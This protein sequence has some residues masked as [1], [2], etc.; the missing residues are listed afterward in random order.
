MKGREFRPTCEGLCAFS[1]TFPSRKVFS[2]YLGPLRKTFVLLG[3]RDG[4]LLTYARAAVDKRCPKAD[5]PKPYV[6]LEFMHKILE[7]MGDTPMTRLWVTYFSFGLRLP[8]EGI[9]LCHD[10]SASPGR[11]AIT[12][13]GDNTLKLY[14]PRR[15]NRE[16]ATIALRHCWYHR[17]SQTCPIHKV[18]PVFKGARV[19]TRPLCRFEQQSEH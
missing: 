6:S 19:G 5:K 7:L 12:A 10:P 16:H 15:K 8:P 14:F 1:R 17:S 18:W 4:P 11:F 2:D 9:P 3:L 13:I